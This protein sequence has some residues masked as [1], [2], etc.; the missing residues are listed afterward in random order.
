MPTAKSKAPKP[1]A[2][3]TLNT[4]EA[5]SL[6]LEF[7]SAERYDDAERLF[8]AVLEVEPMNFHARNALGL[9][10][11]EK[12][13][14]Q[15]ALG[16]FD[17]AYL[18][19]LD[20]LMNVSCNR[21]MVLG[22]MGRTR[23]AIAMFD[24]LIRMY[25][26]FSKAY[27]NRGILYMQ[28]KEFERA[29]ADF[30]VVLQREPTNTG[31]IFSRGFCN[32]VLGNYKEGFVGF[33]T[34]KKCEIEP[35]EVPRW[36]PGENLAGKT[37]L[38]HGEQ[39]LGDNIQF[40][41]FVPMLRAAG[42]NVKVVL[43]TPVEPLAGALDCEIVPFDRKKWGHFDCWSPIMS[44]AYCFGTTMETVPPPTPL[45]YS[46]VLES[47]WRSRIPADGKL[48][49]GLCWSG[50]RISKYDA[51]R[52]VPVADTIPLFD[53]PGVTFYSFQKDVRERDQAAFA[54]L[55]SRGL[56]DLEPHLTDFQQT[57][58]AMKQL[59]LMITCDTSVAHMAG[60]V[61]VP[62]WVMLTDF[63]AYWL[64]THNR[65]N[66]AWYPSVRIFRQKRDGDWQNTLGDWKEVVARIKA[67]F[68]ERYA[69]VA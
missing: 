57:A 8:R 5:L 27:L 10:I 18:S 64:W 9:C 21:G 67:Q 48:N 52:S 55:K 2:E 63:R 13:D 16:E 44:L 58:H 56:V 68:S 32:L 33:E 24:G 53:L 20:G 29:K 22:E 15:R 66:C 37:I 35:I 49:V 28:I 1:P 6:A 65:E 54:E 42:A 25:P 4:G 19:V 11:A 30:S 43:P 31:A 45:R 46:L 47:I 62:T 59:D 41:R 39:G 12:G 14:W 50:N 26:A 17:Q 60:T 23:E 51:Y 38:V 40:L 3:V 61:G 36:Q 69:A 34:R 7:Y